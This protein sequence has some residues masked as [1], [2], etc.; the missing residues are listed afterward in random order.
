MR[1]VRFDRPFGDIIKQGLGFLCAWVY[2]TQHHPPS[3]FLSS[4]AVYSPVRFACLVSCRHHLWDSKSLAA[5]RD[6]EQT[7]LFPKEPASPRLYQRLDHGAIN[8]CSTLNHRERRRIAGTFT[9]DSTALARSRRL[10]KHSTRVWLRSANHMR[11]WHEPSAKPTT[12][13]KLRTNDAQSNEMI[14][15]RSNELETT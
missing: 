8:A 10:C 3:S 4:S 7:C 15:V 2:R 9:S 11:R 14:T 12:I 6:T 13:V 5:C 1:L